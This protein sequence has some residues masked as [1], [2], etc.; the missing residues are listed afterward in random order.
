MLKIVAGHSKALPAANCGR[1]RSARSLG[2]ETFEWAKAALG[3]TLN[4]FYGQTECNLVLGSC[5]AI[6]VGR[7]GRI[8]KV[9]SGPSRWRSST[10][11]AGG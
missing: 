3:V 1:L 4:E 8:G 2:R 10:A 5:A 6:G 9:V 11:R 7:A